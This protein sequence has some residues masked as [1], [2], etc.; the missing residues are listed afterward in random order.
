MKNICF[1]AGTRPEII[2]IAPV[3]HEFKTNGAGQLN[4]IFCAT[5][6]HK[7]MADQ[8]MQIFDI[9]PDHNLEIMSEN[10]TLNSISAKLFS[11]L[12]PFFDVIKPD[13]VFVQGDTTT[14]AMT[15]LVAFNM[16]IKVAHIEAGLRT[17]NLDAPFPEELNRRLVSNFSSF[18][19]APTEHAKSN[20]L[21]E[22]CDPESIIVTG[23][24][25]VDALEMI[26]KKYNLE[27][28]F[29]KVFSFKKPFI[30][31]TAHRRESFGQGFE[32]ICEAIN[33][34]ARRYNDIDI[35][36]P[37]HMNP[38]VRVPVEKHL[39]GHSNIRLIEPVSYIE[40]LS[41][42]NKCL[43]CVTDSGGIQEEAPSFGKYTIVLRDFTERTESVDMGLSELVGTSLIK[44]IDAIENRLSIKTEH[45]TLV[46]NPFGNGNAAR[47]IFQ[48][49]TKHFF[50]D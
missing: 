36:Y 1:I 32:N 39:K 3:I 7:T 37:V 47:E 35:I 29:N 13:I 24:T 33:E 9:V 20:L 34:I 2:K 48:V 6:Q 10:Q 16:R 25:V 17:Y 40:L 19:F 4:T 44:I 27:T 15:G 31:L 22:N 45:A 38:N 21:R 26:K 30:L 8:A 14:V 49:I 28:I 46:M 11:L 18:N 41:L 5:G 12:P 42:L 43:F 23:N 50:H